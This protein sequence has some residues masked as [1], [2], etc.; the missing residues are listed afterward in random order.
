MNNLSNIQHIRYTDLKLFCFSVSPLFRVIPPTQLLANLGPSGESAFFLVL[1]FI[2]IFCI[3]LILPILIILLILLILIV[4]PTSSKYQKAVW[5]SHIKCISAFLNAV[6][7][8]RLCMFS[9]AKSF[10]RYSLNSCLLTLESSDESLYS[11]GRIPSC[12][13]AASSFVSLLVREGNL[14]FYTSHVRFP[15]HLEMDSPWSRM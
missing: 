15:Q 2:L 1:R 3:L 7:V 14:P 5:G 4:C 10:W 8:I 12:M 9:G 13:R 11:V 6:Q